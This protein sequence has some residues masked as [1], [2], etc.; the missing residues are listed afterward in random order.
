MSI[1]SLSHINSTPE[2]SAKKQID[3]DKTDKQN[4]FETSQAKSSVQNQSAKDIAKSQIQ[5]F[6]S[7][8]ELNPESSHFLI[9][10]SKTTKEDGFDCEEY[11]HLDGS[12]TIVKNVSQN[13]VE[14]VCTFT[15]VY[16]REKIIEQYDKHG[17]LEK[18]TH[19]SK[20]GSY[21]VL[22][23]DENGEIESCADVT[24]D[25]SENKIAQVELKEF[26]NEG[27]YKLTTK[28]YNKVTNEKTNLE[29]VESK[30]KEKFFDRDDNEIT[31]EQYY[32]F[33]KFALGF[34]AS[35]FV[36]EVVNDLK[37]ESK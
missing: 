19:Y 1:N 22:K 26:N 3:T 36:E 2:I 15:S 17:N 24:F 33:T 11:K 6:L 7:A 14:K 35:L 10:P 21:S 16:E 29:D 8:N 5:S 31:S 12:K 32:G 37:E 34:I 20:D 23:Y 27:Q 25:K 28:T 13:F 9:L 30:Q 4:S 18:E